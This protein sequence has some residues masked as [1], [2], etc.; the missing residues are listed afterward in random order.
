M[1]HKNSAVTVPPPP[2]F[3]MHERIQIVLSFLFFMPLVFAIVWCGL[4]IFF[5]GFGFESAV[6]QPVY[7]ELALAVTIVCVAFGRWNAVSCRHRLTRQRK[8]HLDQAAAE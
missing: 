3:S 1:S 8:K 7:R 5:P 6:T 2:E 4:T